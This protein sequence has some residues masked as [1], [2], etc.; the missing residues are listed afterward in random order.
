MRARLLCAGTLALVAMVVAGF[1]GPWAAPLD[2]LV[3]FRAH[4]GVALLVLA[5]ALLALRRRKSAAAGGLGAALALAFSLPWLLP[6][7]QAPGNGPVYSLLQMNLLYRS[8]DMA[9]ALQRIGEAQPDVITVQEITPQWRARLAPLDAAYPHQLHCE[10]AD[11]FSGDSAIYSRRPFVE[12]APTLC[13]SENSLAMARIDF[14]GVGVTVISHHQLWPWPAGQWSRFGR[15]RETLA[16]LPAP[17]LA[18]GDFNAAPWSALLAAYAETTGARV[19]PGVG[20]TWLTE[21]L[22]MEWGRWIGLPL[23]NLLASP[24]IAPAGI[25]RLAA[26]GSDHLPVLLTFRLQPPGPPADEVRMVDARR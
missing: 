9:A 25:R 23:N 8:T 11:G 22:P 2:S 16:S 13:D 15:L 18:A 12:D 10:D 26:T 17:L 5:L 6:A 24:E 1:A 21:A 3:H 4:L 19:L 14:N 20:P 7:S